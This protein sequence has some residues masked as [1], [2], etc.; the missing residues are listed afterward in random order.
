VSGQKQVT[1]TV[2]IGAAAPHKNSTKPETVLKA[3]DLILYKAKKAGRNRV[4]IQ[5]TSG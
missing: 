2:S 5:N 3:A 1:V 4:M